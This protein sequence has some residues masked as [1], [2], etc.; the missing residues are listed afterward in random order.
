MQREDDLTDD[1]CAVQSHGKDNFQ[2][3]EVAE[4]QTELAVQRNDCILVTMHGLSVCDSLAVMINSALQPAVKIEDL[5]EPGAVALSIWLALNKQV[6]TQH[7]H[8]S[9]P[10]NALMAAPRSHHISPILGSSDGNYEKQSQKQKGL[11][12]QWESITSL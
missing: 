4:W 7:F 11:Q 2:Q 1:G 12:V 9:A 3:V 5:R 8:R 10:Q 6:P